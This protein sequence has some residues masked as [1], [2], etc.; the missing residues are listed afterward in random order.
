QAAGTAAAIAADRSLAP[1]EVP[2]AD[3]RAALKVQG[4]YLSDV[5]AM[6]DG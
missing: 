1:S 6:A 3:L 5:P 2:I 4:A